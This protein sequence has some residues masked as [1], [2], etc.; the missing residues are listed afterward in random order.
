MAS[1]KCLSLPSLAHEVFVFTLASSHGS[2]GLIEELL[3]HRLF[4]EK[5]LFSGRL[6]FVLFCG[7]YELRK[8]MVFTERKFFL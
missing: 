3:H 6:G 7:V 8:I 2:K 1:S 5:G 4:R